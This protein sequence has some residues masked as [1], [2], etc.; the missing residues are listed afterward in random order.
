MNVQLQHYQYQ[1]FSI[2]RLYQLANLS[3]PLSYVVSSEVLEIMSLKY[4][5]YFYGDQSDTSKTRIW[6]KHL[7]LLISYIIK[8]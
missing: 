2:L 8:Y 7:Q 1:V 6:L 4:L 3:V 5:I